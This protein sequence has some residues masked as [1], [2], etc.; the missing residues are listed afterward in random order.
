MEHRGL[1]VVAGEVE[2]GVGTGA[3]D[4][5]VFQSDCV[6]AYVAS[7]TARGFSPV[8]IENATGLLDR[9]LDLLGRPAWEVD[10]EDVD[11]LVGTLAADG[12]SVADHCRSAALHTSSR[13]DAVR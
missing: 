13:P 11:R 8:T 10:V 1:R 5:A 2:P 3:L 4:P 6:A 7:W 9:T 12:L